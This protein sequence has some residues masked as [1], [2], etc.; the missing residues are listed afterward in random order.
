M[1]GLAHVVVVARH[2]Q[3]I[4]SDGLQIVVDIVAAAQTV[5]ECLETQKVE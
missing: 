5:G 1:V 2:F 4:H 3:V